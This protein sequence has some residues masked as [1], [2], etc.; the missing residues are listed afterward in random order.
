MV[1]NRF[2][3]LLILLFSA[4]SVFAQTNSLESYQVSS[5][6]GVTRISFTFSQR[7]I[8]NVKKEANALRLNIAIPN[9]NIATGVP[10]TFSTTDMFARN[11]AITRQNRGLNIEITTDQAFESIRQSASQTRQHTVHIDIFRHTEPRQLSDFVSHLDYFNYVRNEQRVNELLRSANAAFPNNE[12]ISLR[13]QNRFTSPR[14]SLPQAQRNQ[15]AQVAQQAQPA[16]TTQ[17]AQPARTAQQAQPTQRAQGGRPSPTPVPIP[18]QADPAP[19]P[20]PVRRAEPA[21]PAQ[22]TAPVTPPAQRQETPP[23]APP[24][25]PAPTPPVTPAPAARPATLELP[26]ATTV[27][28]VEQRE[29]SHTL[30]SR[31]DRFPTRIPQTV[32]IPVQQQQIVATPPVEAVVER[33]PEPTR[34]VAEPIRR[35]PEPVRPAPVVAEPQIVHRTV[36]DTVGLSE[37]ARLIMSYH[38]IATIDSVLIAFMLGTNANLVGDFENAVNFL[39]QIPVTDINYKAAL[40]LL[41]DSYLSIGDMVNANFYASLLAAFDESEDIDFINTPIQLWMAF[42]VG[43]LMFIVGIIIASVTRNAKKSKKKETSDKD[44]DVHRKNLQRAY[45]QKNIYR[46]EVT[47]PKSTTDSHTDAVIGDDYENPPIVTEEI[48]EDEE[49]EL[50]QSEKTNIPKPKAA[51]PD[52]KKVADDYEPEA[53]IDSEYRKKMVLKLY[54]DGWKLDEISKELQ[55]SRGEIDFILKMNF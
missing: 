34:P 29:I 30:I 43:G 2:V 45:E 17:Q 41:Y 51:E 32:V 38:N 42:A 9:S 26:A 25:Q 11:I 19:P 20:P 6:N 8:T 22:R 55:M 3:V 1:V 37:T 27:R 44:L 40:K 28:N 13:E 18:T 4:V 10:A 31:N 16:R 21:A 53:Y 23:P 35:E 33:V 50:L 5:F 47:P 49:K 48:S 12:Q 7:P 39:R 46:Q 14:V 15:P 52:D 36:I 24:V 54:N